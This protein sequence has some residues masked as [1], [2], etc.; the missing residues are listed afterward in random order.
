MSTGQGRADRGRAAWSNAVDPL[1]HVQR[2]RSSG[3]GV[4]PDMAAA[5]IERAELLLDSGR[6]AEALAPAQTAVDIHL[7]LDAPGPG[8]PE[9]GMH[10]TGAHPLGL[11]AALTV[12]AR[13]LAAVARHEEAAAMSGHAVRLSTRLA[14]SD[15]DAR[16]GCAAAL[17]AHAH[18]LAEAEGPGAALEASARALRLYEELADTSADA[19]PTDVAA[20]LAFHADCLAQL[21]RLPEAL[22]ASIRSVRLYKAL[23]ITADPCRPGHAE[24]FLVHAEVLHR[25]GETADAL[26]FAQRAV[27]LRTTLAQEYLRSDRRE[28]LL[29]AEGTGWTQFRAEVS[30]LAGAQVHQARILADAG[31]RAA[32]LSTSGCAVEHRSRLNATE[33]GSYLPELA[34]SQALF[35]DIRVAIGTEL[36]KA[37]LSARAAYRA[38]RKLS[39]AEPRAYARKLL[40]V[41]ETLAAVLTALGRTGE[42]EQIRRDLAADVRAAPSPDHAPSPVRVTAPVPPEALEITLLRTE[43]LTAQRGD[44]RAAEATALTRL[45]EEL[46]QA[47]RLEEAVSACESAVA[48]HRAA[49]SRRG[50]AVALFIT[51]ICQMKLGRTEEAI[52]ASRQSADIHRELDDK[53][54]EGGALNNLS[55]ALRAAGRYEEAIEAGRRAA[56]LLHGRDPLGEGIALDDLGIALAAAGRFKEASVSLGQAAEVFRTIGN[57]ECEGAALIDLGGVLIDSGGFAEAV[58]VCQR[59]AAVLHR[60]D[61]RLREG[62]ALHDLGRALARTRRTDQALAAVR[63]AVALF[64]AVGERDW[65]RRALRTLRE[66][67]PG[68]EGAPTAED[69][70]RAQVLAGLFAR[71]GGGDLA[72]PIVQG[73]AQAGLRACGGRIE[74]L[75]NTGHLSAAAHRVAHATVE[76][77]RDVFALVRKPEKAGG[78]G[79][80][81]PR[82]WKAPDNEARHAIR[83]MSVYAA[84]I[85]PDAAGQWVRQNLDPNAMP[86]DRIIRSAIEVLSDVLAGDPAP[87]AGPQGEA[88]ADLRQARQTVDALTAAGRLTDPRARQSEQEKVIDALRRSDRSRRQQELVLGWVLAQLGGIL[89][90]RAVILASGFAAGG[91]RSL[92]DSAVQDAAQAAVFTIQL[93]LIGSHETG[94]LDTESYQALLDQMALLSEDLELASRVGNG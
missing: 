34:N 27:D 85:G 22:R 11:V 74:R 20:T 4:S 38:F 47:G 5:L 62:R 89:L 55:H 84:R 10:R 26:A 6:R 88:D 2:L 68:A 79:D 82:P 81:E 61:D 41:A 7:E 87:A 80:Q 63:Q 33:P 14:E 49:G 36:D 57:G 65:E 50:V 13:A 23:P 72:N 92:A 37:L 39:S 91:S 64:R 25:T 19:L 29:S 93:G 45:G 35:A 56:V 9:L 31:R 94:S 8:V 24:A 28:E 51:G 75:R 46:W 76:D 1:V 12:L 18:R 52:A 60:T 48:C 16:P 3:A 83:D 69:L 70:A 67:T 53:G 30:G 78:A 73:A 54:S 59:A 44:D 32:A 21:G 58:E 15:A 90:D 17:Q 66:L 42:A 86:P 71:M 77:Y 43:R 40:A